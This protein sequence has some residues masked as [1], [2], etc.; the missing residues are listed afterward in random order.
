VFETA[1]TCDCVSY[2]ITNA[3]SAAETKPSQSNHRP[4]MP[5]GDHAKSTDTCTGCTA[6]SH[7]LIMLLLGRMPRG[8][9]ATFM[10]ITCDWMIAA[11]NAAAVSATKAVYDKASLPPAYV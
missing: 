6:V 1:C 8:G 2:P 3:Q 4:S 10:M 5:F 9:A 7:A 11:W